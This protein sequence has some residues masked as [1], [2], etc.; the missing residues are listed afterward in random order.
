M[1]KS[2]RGPMIFEEQ[3]CFSCLFVTRKAEEVCPLFAGTGARGLAEMPQAQSLLL[4]HLYLSGAV[5]RNYSEGIRGDFFPL[6]VGVRPPWFLFL[7][8]LPELGRHQHF[9]ET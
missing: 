1:K 3:D 7:S 5:G 9:D 8:F 6:G 2:D 4:Q